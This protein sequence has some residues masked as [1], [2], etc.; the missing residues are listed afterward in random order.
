MVVSDYLDDTFMI[1]Y[2]TAKGR[3][4]LTYNMYLYFVYILNLKRYF[5]PS[6]SLD[7]HDYQ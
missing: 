3:C 2:I 6:F 4:Q 1:Y 5:T 7:K